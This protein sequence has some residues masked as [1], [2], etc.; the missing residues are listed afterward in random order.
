MPISISCECGAQMQLPDDLAGRQTRCPACQRELQVPGTEIPASP[1]QTVAHSRPPFPRPEPSS[2]TSSV[3]PASNGQATASLVLGCIAFILP[4]ILSVPAIILGFLGLSRVNQSQGRAGGRGR[5]IAGLTLGFV[6]LPLAVLYGY[7]YFRVVKSIKAE[8]ARLTATNNMKQ[9]GLAMQS[10]ADGSGSLPNEAAGR[11]R[12]S[13]RVQILPYLGNEGIRLYPQFRQDEP[14]D[15]PTNKALLS[16]MPRVFLDPRFQ[17]ES[18]RQ[19][20]L[21][22]FRGFVGKDSV[23]GHPSPLALPLIHSGLARTILVVEAGDAVPWTKPEDPS[24]DADSPFG[25]PERTAFLI[26]YADAHVSLAP[27][28]TDRKIIRACISWNSEEVVTPP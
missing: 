10:Y 19:Q 15:S 6:T 25:G 18:D 22:Y 12:L 14:W 21:T 4:V 27:A 2:P 20:G 17:K 16:Q 1:E 7:T 8:A 13:W 3:P 24:F 11:S 23:L 26:L 28:D 9:F 5:A